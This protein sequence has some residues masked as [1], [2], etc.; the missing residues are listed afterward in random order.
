MCMA[1]LLDLCNWIEIVKL[2]KVEEEGQVS[3]MTQCEEEQ[4][5]MLVRAANMV[6]AGESLMKLVASLKEY[7]ILN[8]VKSLND[9]IS[10]RTS[11]L[12]TVQ[13]DSDKKLMVIRD[14]MATDLYDL[15]EDYYSSLYKSIDAQSSQTEAKK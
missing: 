12:A 5:E 3:R 15:E 14:E 1:M 13:R 6:R 10:N 9:A 4:F 8:D 2:A 11:A 7:L